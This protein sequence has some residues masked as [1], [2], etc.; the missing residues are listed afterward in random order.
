MSRKEILTLVV[1]VIVFYL[2]LISL[3][4][5]KEQCEE[6]TSNKIWT[7]ICISKGVN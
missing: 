3:L 2:L 5:K 6:K 1:I 7:R 4:N